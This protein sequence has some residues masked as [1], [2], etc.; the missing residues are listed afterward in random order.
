M[1]LFI[2]TKEF[3][4]MVELVHKEKSAGYTICYY[5]SQIYN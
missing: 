3:N 2:S 5:V 4:E 1:A